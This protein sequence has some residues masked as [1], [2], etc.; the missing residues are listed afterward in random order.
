MMKI[1]MNIS[2]FVNLSSIKSFVPAPAKF[3]LRVKHRPSHARRLSP[4]ETLHARPTK[5]SILVPLDGSDFAERAIPLALGIAEQTSAAIHL[6][7]VIVPTETLAPYDALYFA[8]DSLKS[9]ARD[10]HG[11]L[12]NVIERIGV[13]SSASITSY[14]IEGRDVP[15]S[16]SELSGLHAGLV[17]MATH[18]RGM[19]GR[20]WS[21]SVAYFLLQRLSVPAIFVRGTAGPVALKAKAVEHVLLPCDGSE[22]TR[23]VLRSIFD[24]GLFPRA[25]HSLLHVAPLVPKRVVIE[26]GVATEWTPS[27]DRSFVGMRQLKTLAQTLQKNGRLVDTKTVVSRSEPFG[28]VVVGHA[29]QNDVDLIAAAYRPQWAI[30]RLLWPDASEYLFRKSSRPVL[31]VPSDPVPA[32]SPCA[33]TANTNE[34]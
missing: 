28:Q 23:L 4:R 14:V 15:A 24:L 7:H 12:E 31:F 8:E 16:L 27:W 1:S 2:R 33:S 25:R 17:V 9:L 13:Q 34:E 21:G 22:G 11:Y 20:F 6:V 32:G 30:G 19:L 29:E 26:H 18:G 5:K 10:K 3:A